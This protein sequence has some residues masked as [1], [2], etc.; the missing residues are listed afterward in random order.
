MMTQKSK[1]QFASLPQSDQKLILELC[2]SHEYSEVVEILSRSRSDGG[3]DIRT[4]RAALCRFFTQHQAQSTLGLLAQYAAATSVRHEQNSNAFLG[5]IRAT[6]EARILE[7][8]RAGKAVADM[9]RDFR[10]LKTAEHLYLADARFRAQH[11]KAAS[12]AYTS[13]IQRCADAP[14]LDFVRADEPQPPSSELTS[15][16]S[17]LSDFDLEI[18]KARRRRQDTLAI[19]QSALSPEDLKCHPAEMDPALIPILAKL[20]AKLVPDQTTPAPSFQPKSPVIPPIPENPTKARTSN[21]TFSAPP[22]QVSPA[23]VKPKPHIAAP[24]IA[25]NDPCP[26]GSGRKAKKCCHR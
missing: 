6:V 3:L 23:P 24:R 26:C 19:L 11:P 2:S 25:R 21:S 14:D 22:P 15:H 5:A 13:Y 4:S 18:Q 7:N 8:L 1:S 17:D 9:E 10:F 20:K 12:A 16:S